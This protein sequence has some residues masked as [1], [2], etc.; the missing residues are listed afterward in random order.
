MDSILDASMRSSSIGMSDTDEMS[1]VSMTMTSPAIKAAPIAVPT[2][3]TI[4]LKKLLHMELAF[5][6]CSVSLSISDF[7]SVL[8]LAFMG[9]V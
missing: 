8:F 2:P 5:L 7:L 4:P 9:M 6:N 1:F 3:I